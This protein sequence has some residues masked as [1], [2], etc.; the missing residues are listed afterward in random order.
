MFN[1]ARFC[2]ATQFFE[3]TCDD[4][5]VKKLKKVKHIWLSTHNEQQKL[6]VL[7]EFIE[8]LSHSTRSAS[9]VG[10]VKFFLLFNI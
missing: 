8:N 2:Q 6:D 9:Q 4:I 7:Y 3:I 5:V 10:Y 1:L